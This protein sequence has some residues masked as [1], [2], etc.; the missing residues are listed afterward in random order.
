MELLK[1]FIESMAEKI[2]EQ[3]KLVKAGKDINS[4]DKDSKEEG[5]WFKKSMKVIDN[6]QVTIKNIHIRYED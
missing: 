2:L 3:K 5:Y 6:V 1:D 4:G